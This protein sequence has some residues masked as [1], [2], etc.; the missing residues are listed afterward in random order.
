MEC[1]KNFSLAVSLNKNYTGT[2]I[3]T[4]GVVGNYHWT[5]VD[6]S[7]STKNITGFKNINIYKIKLLGQATPSL[8]ALTGIVTDYGFRV[9]LNG[10]P[11]IIGGTITPNAYSAIENQSSYFLSKYI[12]EIE[13]PDGVQ[14]VSSVELL[15]FQAMGQNAEATNINLRLN[16]MLMFYY[17][18]EGE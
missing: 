12:S 3:K 6:P 9:G 17:K 11:S 1:L 8:T 2:D 13:I 5:V 4:W 14:S 10:Q 7:V 16:F 15:D 18:F